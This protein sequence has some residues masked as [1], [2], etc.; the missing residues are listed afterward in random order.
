MVASACSG[1][2]AAN[3]EDRCWSQA[4]DRVV[5]VTIPAT[6]LR[7]ND[8]V[9][10]P[11]PPAS[12]A[13]IC[14]ISQPRPQ[15]GSRLFRELWRS[16]RHARW[17]RRALIDPRPDQRDLVRA[18]RGKSVAH[19]PGRHFRLGRLTGHVIDQGALLAVSGNNGRR[20]GGAALEDGIP[21]IDAE[22][23]ARLLATVTGGTRALQQRLDLLHE[24]DFL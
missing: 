5:S 14:G 19:G 17:P 23:A 16:E 3:S 15:I 12:A 20:P 9:G 13:G 8:E 1:L 24:I 6:P 2:L 21:A 22:K 11:N 18:Q 7:A 10:C 4:L